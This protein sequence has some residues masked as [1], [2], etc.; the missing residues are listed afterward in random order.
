[1]GGGECG[2]GERDRG[3]SSWKW[4]RALSWWNPD[5]AW[6]SSLSNERE[7]EVSGSS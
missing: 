1:V 7:S 6:W 3:E 4:L 5:D 2:D